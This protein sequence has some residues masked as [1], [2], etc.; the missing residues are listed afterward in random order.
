MTQ[1]PIHA[2]PWRISTS[3]CYE[4]VY[5]ELVRNTVERPDLLLTITNDTWFGTSIGPL[6][7]LQM[8]RMR[9]L[10]NGRYLI[11]GSNNGVTA[12][13]DQMGVVKATLPQFTRDVLR[14]KV[15]I[16]EGST[17][18]AR[19]GSLPILLVCVGLLF[20]CFLKPRRDPYQLPGSAIN[21]E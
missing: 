18:Y 19:W 7:H 14:G 6:Q 12:I 20:A 11:R 4:I 15:N 5:G 8:A 17:P 3:I 2:G 13:V 9:A 16:L 21:R 1:E 10:E